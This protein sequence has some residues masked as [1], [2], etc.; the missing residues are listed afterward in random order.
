[1][2]TVSAPELATVPVPHDG[3]DVAVI[4]NPYEAGY[5]E[6]AVE[7][8]KTQDS[9]ASAPHEPSYSD[10][11]A[12]SGADLFEPE[13]FEQAVQQFISEVEEYAAAVASQDSDAS[14][15]PTPPLIQTREKRPLSR[16]RKVGRAAIR[17]AVIPVVGAASF[18]GVTAISTQVR[19]VVPDRA[20]EAASQPSTATTELAVTTTEAPVTTTTEAATT[21]TMPE[22]PFSAEIG[23]L[24][25]TLSIPSI[26][27]DS[28]E[29]YEQDENDVVYDSS[30]DEW[31]F[32]E[33]API[34]M[35]ELDET[36]L[37]YCEEMPDLPYQDRLERND[38]ASNLGD[39]SRFQ[40]VV[41]HEQNANGPRSV[42]PGQEGNAV[43]FGHRT[44]Y[45]AALNNVEALQPG[46]FIF[47]VRP[48]GE[49]F[50]YRVVGHE[51]IAATDND[52]LYEWSHPDSK[53]TLTLVACS[54]PDGTPTS[55]SH[56]Y[57]VRAVMV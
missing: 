45:N 44:T 51:V 52:V 22:V 19:D 57:L 12:G 14:P 4:L 54:K 5:F 28:I 33:D 30:T 16:T 15:E 48:D 27:E 3:L 56:R 23:E 6:R 53:A 29:I 35:R 38:K 31:H 49:M 55:S 7:Y 47:Y 36:P 46:A 50:T 13:S 18:F 37:E 21:T 26:C 11:L 43:L 9:A 1:M 17:I 25:G 10:R 40:P 2:T 24:S 8:F 42:Y 39:A 34:N 32:S 20:A 41:V